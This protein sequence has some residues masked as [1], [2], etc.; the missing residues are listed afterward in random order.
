MHVRPEKNTRISKTGVKAGL[1]MVPRVA[2]G[3]ST[4]G[5]RKAHPPLVDIYRLLAGM[6]NESV[7]YDNL[8]S[9][10]SWTDPNRS[11]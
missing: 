1:I 10:R 7:R 8:D 4:E 11:S 6:T 9:P 5:L 3:V 2:S